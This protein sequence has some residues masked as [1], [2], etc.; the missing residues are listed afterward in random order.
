ML[1]VLTDPDQFFASRVDD[2]RP[3]QAAAVVLVVGVIG[4]VSGYLLI[5]KLFSSLPDEVAFAGTIAMVFTIGGGLLG[6]FVIWFIYA[7]LFYL[8]SLV[9]DPDGS[10]KTLFGLTGWGFVP[11]V[12]NAIIG[13]VIT[14]MLLGQLQ[15]PSTAQG[16]AQVQAQLQRNSL[17]QLSIGIGILFS[18]WRGF[19]WTFA[20][21]HARSLSLKESAIVVGIPVAAGILITVVTNLL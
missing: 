7:G 15:A 5:Q 8:I 6:P 19:I 20:V 9:F 21:K 4:A 3:L 12:L 1:S 14:I 17:Y 11:M 18:L 10:F 13:L 16:A 2:P